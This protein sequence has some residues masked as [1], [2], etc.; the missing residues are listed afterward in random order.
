MTSATATVPADAPTRATSLRLLQ[1]SVALCLLGVVAQAVNEAF[2]TTVSGGDF[3]YA[4]DYWLTA[5]GLPIAVGGVGLA[6]AVHRLQ[7]GADGRLGTIGVWVNTIALAELFV[8]LFSS[9]VVGAELR[10]GPMY[11]VGT[12]LTFLGIALLA[13]GSW[14]TG[15]LPRWMLGVWPLLWVLGTFFGTLPGCL[16][17]TA[18]LV[19]F[20]VRLTRR[21]R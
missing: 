12:F 4:A 2:F 17:L 18:F 7:R 21:V 8:Q 20:A 1:G 11:V 3:K 15:L 6:L 14:R 5:A 10:W 16:V 9:V 13:A 19:L